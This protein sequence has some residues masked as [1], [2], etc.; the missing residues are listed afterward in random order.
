MEAYPDD[1]CKQKTKL[2][3]LTVFTI[4]VRAERRKILS[5]IRELGHCLK[6]ETGE[7]RSLHFLLQRQCSVEMLLPYW[8]PRLWAEQLL[9][10][11]LLFCFACFFVVFFLNLSSVPY[12]IAF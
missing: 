7:P 5:F 12:F 8:A 10:L 4:H 9:L 6:I 11:L 3:G 1:L 2:T